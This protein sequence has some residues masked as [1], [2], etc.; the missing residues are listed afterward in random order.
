MTD[1]IHLRFAAQA[2]RNA[3][4]V[5]LVDGDAQF[6]YEEILT[7]ARRITLL[8]EHRGLK[9][10]DRV[11]I[12]L[13][14]SPDLVFSILGVLGAGGAYVPIDPRL[15]HARI[16]FLLEDAEPAV[17]LTSTELMP[18]LG[19]HS[20]RAIVLDEPD[21]EAISI[22]YTR[23]E[24]IQDN[25]AYIIY[26]S[27]TTGTPKGVLITH[28]NV[29]RL[30]D[31][32]QERRSFGD[33][34]IWSLVHSPSFDVSVWEMWGALLH[35]G[36]L[37]L[38]REA[39]ICEMRDLLALLL[40]QH[41][42]F[43]SLTPSVFYQLVAEA[44][45]GAPLTT[46]QIRT[47][48]FAG[49][50]LNF[51][52]IESIG[53]IPSRQPIDA[54]NMYGITETT[55]HVTFRLLGREDARET[56]KSLVGQPLPDM[57]IELIGS[58]GHKV[59]TGQPG[60]IRVAGPGLA[61]GYWRRASETARK[62]LPDPWGKYGA[63][64]YASGDFARWHPDGDLEYLG[65]A[66]DQVKVHGHRIELGEVAGRLSSHA[67][68]DDVV[69]CVNGQ[70]MHTQLVAYYVSSDPDTSTEKLRS[71]AAEFLPS[72]MVPHVFV[73]MDRL[74]LTVNGKVDKRSLPPPPA[75]PVL[76]E[77]EFAAAATPKE[78]AL[79]DIWEQALGLSGIGVNDNFFV[80][81][82]DSIKCIQVVAAAREVG[83][84]LTVATVFRH[85][86]VRAICEFLDRAAC[87]RS[88]CA[89]PEPFSLL[90]AHVVQRLPGDVVDAFP[91]SMMLQSLIF[92][93]GFNDDYEIYV[94]S[95]R[96]R[97][98]FCASKLEEAIRRQIELNE[99]LR[100]SFVI[101][102]DGP[103]L[104]LVHRTAPAHLAV[105]DWRP[106]TLQAADRKLRDWLDNEKRTVFEWT[107][108]PLARFCVHLLQ[109]DCFQLT[110]SDASLDGWAVA[111]L[112]TQ[113][114]T[115]YMRLMSD[116]RTPVSPLGTRYAEFAA[117]EKAVL[118]DREAQEFWLS[119]IAEEVPCSIPR[120]A[121]DSS[122]TGPRRRTA[123]RL[124]PEVVGKLRALS[125]NLQV[126]IR[127]VL[128]TSHL[129]ALQRLY[130]RPCIVTGLE[131]NGRPEGRGGDRIIGSFNNVVPFRMT[132]ESQAWPQ[133]VQQVFEHEKRVMPHRRYPYAQL[134]RHNG[135][136]PLFETVFVYTDFYIYDALAE[137]PGLEMVNIEASDDTFFPLTFHFNMEGRRSVL[138]VAADYSP[139]EFSESQV[140]PILLGHVDELLAVL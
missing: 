83:F 75:V 123:I 23:P 124:G 126:P 136:Q 11:A 15:P 86:T 84:D 99:Y 69:V 115:D 19:V 78:R 108:A 120:S 64:T 122:G 45:N 63:R 85:G 116:V 8:L 82:G 42:S 96:L 40:E 129:M 88:A 1:C 76:P 139:R 114:L 77:T 57:R 106:L 61:R 54:I 14:R 60:E 125:R 70:G 4:R 34:E 130:G 31:S 135:R 93:S 2:R 121:V 140:E 29:L 97:G 87:S 95:V 109:D 39:T 133:L 111:T 105:H 92:Q 107:R 138:N 3:D 89:A 90:S 41:V 37:I 71:F 38:V 94:T 5:G 21:A 13:S 52:A 36:R 33:A 30:F 134:L 91:A 79:L 18:C 74:P 26:T 104:Q 118:L 58:N 43:L 113:L 98:R 46:S 102:D 25:L 16:D 128:L 110:V 119:Q 6:T 101:P 9:C 81:G 24:P 62:F 137:L 132:L 44:S 127:S 35:G 117:L 51:S 112:V 55:V 67:S 131:L 73:R 47:I 49:E 56:A 17:I 80:V 28:A 10:E 68:I 66:D 7:R 50:K 53:R 20:S 12:L 32:F 103:P 72:Y 100:M 59:P 48:V 27:G 65:R 22:P